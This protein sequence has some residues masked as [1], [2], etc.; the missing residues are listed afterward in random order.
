MNAAVFPSGRAGR[1]DR[2]TARDQGGHM[3]SL[4]ERLTDSTWKTIAWAGFLLITVGSIDYVTGYE[5]SLSVFYLLPVLLVV[6]NTN[7]R[8]GLFFSALAAVS[9]FL[10]DHWFVH[11]PYSQPFIPYWNTVV[12]LAFFVTFAILGDRIKSLLRKE[13]EHSKLKSSMIHTVSHEFNNSLTVLASGLFLLRE[14]E[15]EPADATR[16][17]VLTAMEETRVQMSRYIKNIL[18]EGRMETGK[19]ILERSTLALRDIVN[20]SLVP[21]MGLLD[22]KGL[23]LELKFPESRVLVGADRDALALV[24][25]NLLANAVKYTPQGGRI[26]VSIA[27]RGEAPGKVV[28][29]V[30]DTGIGISLT[31]IDKLTTDFYRTET[32]KTTAEGFGLGLKITNELLTLHGSRLEIFSEKGKGSRFFFELPALPPESSAS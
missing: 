23:K 1:F 14:T 4:I 15:P 7:L 32:G 29:S 9:W 6:W 2:D 17:K 12:R 24:V 30:E 16:L 19:F 13:R 5:I 28:F 10:N 18:N 25:S 31:D 20:E 3:F 8:S 21:M 26:I 27:L 22:T 11:H